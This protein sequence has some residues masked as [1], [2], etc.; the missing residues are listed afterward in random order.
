[1]LLVLQFRPGRLPDRRNAVSAGWPGGFRLGGPHDGLLLGA[2]AT[3]MTMLG[4]MGEAPKLEPEESLASSRAGH[5]AAPAC[6]SSSA[7][8]RRA[9]PRCARSRAT[10]MER[11]AAGVMIAPPPSLRTDDQIVGYY[12]RP[13][14]RSATDVPFVIQDYPLTLQRG[15]DAGGDPPHRRGQSVL[16]DAEARGLAGTREDLGAARASRRT[17]DAATSRS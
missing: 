3:G 13:S 8:R 10:S 7:S 14:R 11:G 15:D 17:A 2:G 4:I 16:R 5:R 1:M 12:G 6:R 9:L